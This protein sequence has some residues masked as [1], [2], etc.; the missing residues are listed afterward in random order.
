MGFIA[1]CFFFIQSEN[2]CLI[3]H[4]SDLP[5]D[6]YNRINEHKQ[7]QIQYLSSSIANY[8]NNYFYV[9]QKALL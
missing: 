1:A 6:I 3:H 9:N 4:D 5:Y 8:F 7:R 2:L